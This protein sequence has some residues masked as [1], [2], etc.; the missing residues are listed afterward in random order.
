M[1]V[2]IT[3]ASRGIGAGLAAQYAAAGQEVIGTGRSAG[4]Q[5]TLDVTQ[6][7]SHSE[8]AEALGVSASYLN[9]IERNQRP[10]TAQF[11]LRLSETYDVDLK[12]FAGADDARQ[13]AAL[14]EAFADPALAGHTV[15]A[16]ELQDV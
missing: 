3:G 16:Q 1:T 7:K 12:T 8:M 10:V 13:V 5:L 4:A 11:L 2:L 14:K 15:D 9:L 6:P